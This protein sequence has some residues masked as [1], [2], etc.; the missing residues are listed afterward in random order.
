MSQFCQAERFEQVSQADSRLLARV[1]ILG[2]LESTIT[3]V[4]LGRML[5]GLLMA[6]RRRSHM[7]GT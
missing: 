4:P 1:F 7:G 2:A 6:I 5:E 3:R